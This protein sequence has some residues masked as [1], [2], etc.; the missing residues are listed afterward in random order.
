[1]ARAGGH[2]VRADIGRAV[3]HEHKEAACRRVG[4]KTHESAVRRKSR[5]KSDRKE[6]G[7]RGYKREHR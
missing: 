2:A 4:R 5:V 7:A 3:L 1:M 6:K